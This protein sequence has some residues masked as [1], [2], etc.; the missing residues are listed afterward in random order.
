ME[1]SNSWICSSILYSGN[2][3]EV[4]NL[5]Q[6]KKELNAYTPMGVRLQIA[7][8]KLSQYHWRAI[9]PNLIL[10]AKATRYTVPAVYMV[11]IE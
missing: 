7:K 4:F 11:S 1:S 6:I 8:F 9:S 3:G 5:Y 10:L 2:F